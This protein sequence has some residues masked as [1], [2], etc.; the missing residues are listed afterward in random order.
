MTHAK[1]GVVNSSAGRQRR[2]WQEAGPALRDPPGVPR[3]RCGRPPEP[4]GGPGAVPASSRLTLHRRASPSPTSCAPE[5]NPCPEGRRGSDVS[6]RPAPAVRL[7]CHWCPAVQGQRGRPRKNERSHLPPRE[8]PNPSSCRRRHHGAVDL[9]KAGCPRPAP[10]AH[11]RADD[12]TPR[13]SHLQPDSPGGHQPTSIDCSPLFSR[14]ARQPTDDLLPGWPPQGRLRRRSTS[15]A[16]PLDPATQSQDRAATR[17]TGEQCSHHNPTPALRSV[18][19]T[20][21][22]HHRADAA[23]YAGVCI[24]L[25]FRRA[26]HVPRDE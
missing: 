15:A 16:A 10:T 5:P 17:G 1:A 13:R 7:S 3:G 14:P 19:G 21:K 22:T 8:T 26:P 12:H 20:G 11:A 4:S 18:A 24:G 2:R 9:G 25:T 23:T 6:T